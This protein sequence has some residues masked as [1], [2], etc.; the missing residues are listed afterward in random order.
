[1]IDLHPQ[2]IN[3]GKRKEFVVLPYTEFVALQALL[4]DA[5]DLLQLRQ[6]KADEGDEPAISLDDVKQRLKA[7]SR[8]A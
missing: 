7:K 5:E 4:A 1:M 8:R 6:A 2:V 3:R